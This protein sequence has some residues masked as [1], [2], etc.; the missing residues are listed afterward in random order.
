M[1]I[2]AT[3]DKPQRGTAVAEA[4]IH[5][6]EGPLTGY[7][8]E[9]FSIRSKDGKLFATLPSRSYT[10]HDGAKKFWDLLRFEGQGDGK[11]TLSNWLVAEYQKTSGGGDSQADG[12]ADQAPF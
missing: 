1:T 9:G 10:G 11:W 8:L 4:K 3:F 6:Q 7:A 12:F 2:F 5:F